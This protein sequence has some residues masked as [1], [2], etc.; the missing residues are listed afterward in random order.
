MKHL[1]VLKGAYETPDGT[2]L[3]PKIPGLGGKKTEAVLLCR[4][5]QNLLQGAGGRG[6]DGGTK[7]RRDGKTE[8]L[9]YRQN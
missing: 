5:Q 6:Q 1:K 9:L 7:R 4:S 8:R 3:R 2:L